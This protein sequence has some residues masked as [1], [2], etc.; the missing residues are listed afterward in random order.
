AVGARRGRREPQRPEARPRT[1]QALPRQAHGTH[2]AGRMERVRR[3]LMQGASRSPRGRPFERPFGREGKGQVKG[4]GGGGQAAGA[5]RTPWRAMGGR[6]GLYAPGPHWAG[7]VLYLRRWP[8][9][10]PSFG[11]PRKAV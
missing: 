6:E 7:V 8:Q 11:G 9:G 4:G 10:W 5:P 1:V 3:D 2:I